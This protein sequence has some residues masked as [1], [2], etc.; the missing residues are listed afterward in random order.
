MQESVYHRRKAEA[1]TRITQAAAGLVE[2][3]HLDPALLDGLNPPKRF[4]ANTQ[5]LFTLEAAA[6]ILESALV[7]VTSQAAG[8]A[9]AETP[10]QGAARLQGKRAK[11]TVEV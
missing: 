6:G 7:V 8:Q 2:T 10:A 9:Q 1:L 5:H 11:P 4:D 3:L